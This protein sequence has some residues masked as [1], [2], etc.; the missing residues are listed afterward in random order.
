[1]ET[2]HFPAREGLPKARVWVCERFAFHL[3]WCK[4]SSFENKMFE[5]ISVTL[6]LESRL[7]IQEEA[8]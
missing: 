7:E 3:P 4:T 2:G 6:E 8:G 1:M 5:N